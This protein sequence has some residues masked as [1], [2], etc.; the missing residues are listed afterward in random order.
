VSDLIGLTIDRY[1]IVE[2]IGAGGMAVVY[3]AFDPAMDRYVAI[4]IPRQELTSDPTFRARFT[5]EARVLAKLEHPHILPVHDFGEEN[6]RFYLVMRYVGE[7]SLREM[8][9]RGPLPLDQAVR[10]IGQVA[11]ALAYAHRNQVIHRDVKPANVLVDQEGS[12]LL[13]DFGIAKLLQE[14]MHLTGT[15]ESI[16]TP[17]Y[18]SP[19]QVR[20]QP[21][22]ARTDIYALGVVLYEV[23]T[24]RCPFVAETPLAVALM[25]L[26]DP[27]PL[28][29]EVNPTLPEALERIILR[30]MAK[31][32]ADRFQTADEFAIALREAPIEPSQPMAVEKTLVAPIAPSPTEPISVVRERSL[33]SPTE[34]PGTTERTIPPRLPVARARN[35]TALVTELAPRSL[36][37][38]PAVA[39]PPAMSP[40]LGEAKSGKFGD[41][42]T[43]A[44]G[45]RSRSPD[46]MESQAG[47][48][49]VAGESL[50]ALLEGLAG[51]KVPQ[52][53]S[54]EPRPVE[55]AEPKL[56]KTVP[57]Q[58]AARS[59]ATAPLRASK[60]QKEE[61]EVQQS[62]AKILGW[63]LVWVVLAGGVLL[64]I[65]IIVLIVMLNQPTAP[66]AN[67][68]GSIVIPTPVPTT[69]PLSTW[70]TPAPVRQVVFDDFS[71]PTKGA[72]PKSSSD[73]THY[74]VGYVG[75]D[76]V[77]K[78][79]DPSFDSDVVLT[80]SGTFDDAVV[81]IDARVVSMAADRYAF[82]EC[83]ADVNRKS[84]YVL[85]ID[86]SQRRFEL[87]RL[88]TDRFATLV[89][90]QT[91]GA[92]NRG[93]SANHLELSCIG[94]TIFARINGTPVASVQDSTYRT[95]RMQIGAGVFAASTTVH[96]FEVHFNNFSISA[97]VSSP[98]TPT[99]SATRASKPPTPSSATASP[100]AASWQIFATVPGSPSDVALDARGNVYVTDFVN[101]RI[102]RL[103]PTGQP[104]AQ[105]GEE[106]SRPGQFDGPSGIALDAQGNLYV[107]DSVN[108]RIQKL[109]PTGQTLAEWGEEGLGPG[110]FH[111][112]SGIALDAHGNVYVTDLGNNRIQKL[113][114]TGQML[115]EWGEK[116][117][118]P[119]QFDGPSG[120]AIDAQGNLYVADS[121]NNRIQKLSPAGQP[122]AQWGGSG[123]GP[124]RFDGPGGLAVDAQGNIYVADIGNDRIQKLSPSRQLSAD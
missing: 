43:T 80:D 59:G 28:P 77:I 81:A 18:M 124:G 7:G 86:P 21:V 49:A 104:L 6:G 66:R 68:P 57:H 8:I 31:N 55:P 29:H 101:D 24:G 15:S 22:D 51:S 94:S 46:G 85:L 38:E 54:V 20:G 60:T 23:L 99:S 65:G 93:N 117:A 96:T 37:R 91:S 88:D 2:Q 40:P 16:G 26:N 122:L 14:T 50:I 32:P 12:A 13:T 83:R 70:P 114:P 89:G 73:P 25:H 19:E 115:A 1:R 63:P 62:T 92:I 34:K 74:T 39:E 109:S 47:G 79:V 121:E 123:T 41:V 84:E 30:A 111:T 33:P 105:W 110:Q 72:F 106:G 87:N 11:E 102:Q 44:A 75:G 45:E 58:V 56:V 107:A 42:G 67:A 10:L 35:E 53:K 120:I 113:S 3:K 61:P 36:G 17:Y 78:V 69:S 27:L 103:S 100:I 112:P 76:Y 119:G 90:W 108:S 9:A 97:F 71:N 52:S 98:P 118:G 64:P 48:Q 82:V 5:R 4:K 116:G 95:G